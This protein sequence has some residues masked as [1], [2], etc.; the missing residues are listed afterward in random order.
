M[1][2]ENYEDEQ[3]IYQLFIQYMEPN[4]YCSVKILTIILI[5]Y[6]AFDKVT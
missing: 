1:I 3:T 5:K 2:R 6:F 4:C